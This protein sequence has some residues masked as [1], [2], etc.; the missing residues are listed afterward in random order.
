MKFECLSTTH[1]FCIRL[2][3]SADITLALSRHRWFW[4][5]GWRPIGVE[6]GDEI[7]LGWAGL[8]WGWNLGRVGVGYSLVSAFPL[9]D[10][11]ELRQLEQVCLSVSMRVCVFC[12]LHF[13][14]FCL[15]GFCIMERA[16]ER[17]RERERE[18]AGTKRELGEENALPGI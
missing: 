15:L 12:V 3:T 9:H 7:G 11:V 10:V 4:L 1:I 18:R 17:E 13:V 5:L 14:C 8:G 6:T 16:R 2:R